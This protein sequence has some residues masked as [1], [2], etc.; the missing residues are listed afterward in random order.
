MKTMYLSNKKLRNIIRE[1]VRRVLNEGFGEEVS[2]TVKKWFDFEDGEDTL[3]YAE[4]Y[5]DVENT[6]FDWEEPYYEV[7]ITGVYPLN[8]ETEGYKHL[9]DEQME[10]VKNTLMH[11]D[12][13]EEAI[14]ALHNS[15]PE[16]EC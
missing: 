2:F 13:N 6:S 12:F 1:S 10:D 3:V 14:E 5:A 4:V 11:E 9:T 16:L 15:W 7:T 8:N